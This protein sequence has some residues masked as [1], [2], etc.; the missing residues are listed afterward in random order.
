MR[1]FLVSVLMLILLSSLLGTDVQA[2]SE[3]LDKENLEYGVVGV[4]Y[5]KED[6]IRYKVA[7]SKGSETY[8]Y[9]YIGPGIEF[10]PLQLGN[11]EYEISLLKNVSG[12][13]YM[14]VHNDTVRLNLDNENVIYLQSIQNVHYEPEMSAIKKA[15][16]LTDGLS[17][18]FD[19][20]KAVYRFI[21]SNM[22]YDYNFGS[23]MDKPYVP[24]IEKTY[25]TRKGVCYD[26]AS[27]FA[28][29]L[30]TQGIPVKLVKG[31]SNNIEGYHAWNEV[32]IDG[33]WVTI[34]TTYDLTMKGYKELSM[35]K[36]KSEYMP[37]KYY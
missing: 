33:T 14:V 7:I 31:Y 34:D 26:F 13:K 15:E 30:R 28:A 3:F 10:Y 37:E 18:N 19:K 9:D 25:T 24:D 36:N 21:V 8:Y 32:L 4:T 20:V 5:P 23:K 27:L 6:S 2:Y 16:E 11:G 29:M 35:I 12:S 1:K 17:N 22:E